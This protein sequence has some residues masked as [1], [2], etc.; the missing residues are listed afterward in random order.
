MIEY[1]LPP[2]LAKVGR[3]LY[4]LV[5]LFEYRKYIKQIDKNSPL[6]GIQSKLIG[7]ASDDPSEFFDHYCAYSFWAANKIFKKSNS[8]RILDVGS[9]KILNAI[10]S[11]NYKITSLVLK[12]CM[13]SISNVNYIIHDVSNPLPFEDSSFDIFTSTATLPLIGLARYGDKLDVNSLPN[14]IKELD[15]VIVPNGE[16][17]IS[18]CLGP[19][20]LAFNNGWFL[21]FQTIKSIFDGWKLVDYLIDNM[22]SPKPNENIL[23]GERFR[24]NIEIDEIPI[25]RYKVIFLHFIKSIKKIS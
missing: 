20:F 22:S 6:K 9:T 15:R 10:V 2:F 21:N 1:I 16:L 14:F 19:N 25:G 18:M 7:D 5:Q 3:K 11:V 17:I 24:K 23:T 4:I 12:D 13:D 8:I